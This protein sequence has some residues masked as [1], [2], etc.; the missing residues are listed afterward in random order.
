MISA[1]AEA[2][3]RVVN[4][5][6]GGL[7]AVI[8]VITVA[9]VWWRYAL[10]SPIAWTEQVSNMLFVW[11]VFLGAA[12]LYRQ[13]LHIGVDMF[14]NMLPARF[15]DVAFWAIEICNILFVIVLFIFS[16]G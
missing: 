6:L 5:V 9:A 11:I 7:I 16:L 3:T 12:V 14:V 2:V 15:K 1:I 8:V 13:K 4:A 10:N